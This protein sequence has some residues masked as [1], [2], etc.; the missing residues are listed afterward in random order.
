MKYALVQKV[1]FR[2]TGTPRIVWAYVLADREGLSLLLV[3]KPDSNHSHS[4]VIAA[5][6][7]SDRVFEPVKT[8][9]IQIETGD[10][11]EIGKKLR[12]I[13]KSFWEADFRKLLDL[14]DL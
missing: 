10:M 1:A 2:L 4:I 12:V 14:E 9:Q 3:P 5:E 7:L 11:E 13:G 8:S 6:N